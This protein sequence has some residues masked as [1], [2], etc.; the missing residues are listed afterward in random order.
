MRRLFVLASVLLLSASCGGADARPEPPSGAVDPGVHGLATP[1]ERAA[2]APDPAAAALGGVPGGLPTIGGVPGGIPTVPPV[3]APPAPQPGEAAGSVVMT[4]EH[5]ETLG[6]KFAE[7]SMQGASGPVHREAEGVGRTFADRCAHDMV[8]Q[9]V[10]L[11]EY[12][13]MLRARAADE[14]LG[15]KR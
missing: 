1:G 8:G 2:R 14:L 4:R 12:Q 3:G 6:R 9:T 10:P 15:C 11:A 5:C 7:L 13:C